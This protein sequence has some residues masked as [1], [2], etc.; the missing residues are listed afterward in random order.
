MDVERIILSEGG[1][2][3]EDKHLPCPVCLML[4]PSSSFSTTE[5][6]DFVSFTVSIVGPEIKPLLPG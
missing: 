4:Q 2:T 6:L 1:Q 5:Q 3:E